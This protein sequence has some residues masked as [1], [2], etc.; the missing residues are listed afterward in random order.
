MNACAPMEFMAHEFT[1]IV[2][3][4]CVEFQGDLV[5]CLRL[6]CSVQIQHSKPFT[7][8]PSQFIVEERYYN[9]E[10]PYFMNGYCELKYS[11]QCVVWNSLSGDAKTMYVL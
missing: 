10:H 5:V 7:P 3:F 11:M 1:F 8:P 4:T 9:F 6:T 2:H